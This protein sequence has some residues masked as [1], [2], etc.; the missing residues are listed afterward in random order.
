MRKIKD[1]FS[2]MGVKRQRRW[3]LR[4]LKEKRCT[5]CGNPQESGGL[6]AECKAKRRVKKPATPEENEAKCCDCQTCD[7]TET[8]A[9]N[10]AE[11]VQVQVEQA[12]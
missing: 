11:P 3:Q 4:M 9:Q 8:V 1:E 2:E 10:S 12:T 7:C 6:C 5:R